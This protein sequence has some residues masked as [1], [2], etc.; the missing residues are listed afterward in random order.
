V[1]VAVDGTDVVTAEDLGSHL[2]L[3]TRPGDVVEVTVLR[4]GTERTVELELG[5]R[6]TR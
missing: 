5:S 2:A 1:V 6:P 4:D 3:R